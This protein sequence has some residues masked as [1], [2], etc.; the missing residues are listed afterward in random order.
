LVREIRTKYETLFGEPLHLIRVDAE[1]IPLHEA[2]RTYL[3]NSQIL[4]LPHGDM[5]MVCP[6]QCEQSAAVR[7]LIGTWVADARNPIAA[8][9]YVHLSESMANGGGP[10]CLRLRMDWPIGWLN[11]L[12]M[13]SL[14][15][16]RWDERSSQKIKDWIE[17]FYSERLVFDDFQRIDFADYVTLAVREF[18][19]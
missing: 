3:F 8:V 4:S 6:A 16:Y 1:T 18:P 13:P 5:H 7:E 14:A 2:V 19:I 12:A 11:S 17:R 15:K 10:A 9:S